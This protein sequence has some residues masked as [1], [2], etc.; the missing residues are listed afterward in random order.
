MYVILFLLTVRE[1]E[2]GTIG[3]QREESN[4]RK[5]NKGVCEDVAFTYDTGW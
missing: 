5:G 1:S 3:M 4:V 2:R